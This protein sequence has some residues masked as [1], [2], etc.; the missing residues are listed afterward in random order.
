MDNLFSYGCLPAKPEVPLM[1]RPFSWTV[2]LNAILATFSSPCISA[3]GRVKFVRVLF[4]WMNNLLRGL[5]ATLFMLLTS[6]LRSFSF[7][8][9]LWE[10]L[11]LVIL[12]DCTDSPRNGEIQMLE[13]RDICYAVGF[14]L[15]NWILAKLKMKKNVHVLAG[16]RNVHNLWGR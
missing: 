1:E 4:L 11:R 9:H 5:R 15:Q 13:W 6:L 2:L 8:R 3:G 10:G 12:S 16:S 7:G 14:G